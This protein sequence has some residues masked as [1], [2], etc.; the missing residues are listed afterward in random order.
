MRLAIIGAGALGCLLAHTLAPHTPVALLSSRAASAVQIAV[1]GVVCERDGVSSR[2]FLTAVSVSPEA[3]FPCHVALIVVKSHQTPWAAAAAARLLGHGGL[4]VTLQNGLGNREG[5][6]A[7]LGAARV[8]QAVTMLGATLLGPGHVRLAGLG[9]TRFAAQPEPQQ[10]AALAALWEA[11]GFE[12][13]VEPDVQGLVW[14]KLVVNCGI[15]A[16][17]ALLRVPNGTLATLPEARSLLAEAVAEAADVAQAYGVAL[18]FADP[19]AHTLA[20]AEATAANASSMFQD[21]LA[22]RVTE[23]DAINGALVREGLRLGVPT[24]LNALLTRLIAA[25]DA[26]IR[27]H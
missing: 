17:S 9:A 7:V 20:V 24:P 4:A 21:V 26:V 10:V 19:L 3:L 6:A 12:A 15:N 18:P 27:S 16:L 8:G 23:I 13:S 22:G 25:H 5:L 11:A 14:G 2:R 1:Q